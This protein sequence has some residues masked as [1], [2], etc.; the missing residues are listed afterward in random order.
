MTDKFNGAKRSAGPAGK[1]GFSLLVVLII[2]IIGLA[3]V[4]A[5]LQFTVS[6]SGAGRVASASSTK[7]NL[8]QD[9]VEKGK[10]AL[11]AA[12]DNTASPP[13]YP[14]TPGAL[15]KSTD[16]LLLPDTPNPLGNAIYQEFDKGELGRLG[17]AGNSGTLAVQIYDM[18]Y[19]PKN[20]APVGAGADNISPEQLN[21]IPPSIT[22]TG[23]GGINPGMST[24]NANRQRLRRVGGT[25]DNTG[26]YL[27]RAT[28][29]VNDATAAGKTW[30]LET[31]II[32]SNNM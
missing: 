28:L 6:S 27:V 32:Q 24:L 21:L 31:A 9:A 19:D 8:L 4:G 22:V 14:Q 12:M 13:R 20:V 18:Q 5:T 11:K 2:A 17:I 25:A 1:R 30:M 10:A 15:I 3:I 7:Y 23:E 26:V 16:D 29:R